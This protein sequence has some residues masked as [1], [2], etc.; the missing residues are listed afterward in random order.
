L[1]DTLEKIVAFLRTYASLAKSGK[2]PHL[3][4]YKKK[5]VGENFYRKT[6]KILFPVRIF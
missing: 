1:L 2:P 5:G 6:K 4:F 3:S